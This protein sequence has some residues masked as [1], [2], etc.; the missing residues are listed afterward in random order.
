MKI[1]SPKW[2]D[3]SF[4]GVA[5]FLY[6][7][8][9]SSSTRTKRRNRDRKSWKVTYL[10]DGMVGLVVAEGVGDRGDVWDDVSEGGGVTGRAGGRAE[11]TAGGVTSNKPSVRRHAAAWAGSGTLSSA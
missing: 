7:K 10:G 8:R 9:A 5:V 2:I 11:G 3:C 4:S 1:H 6:L